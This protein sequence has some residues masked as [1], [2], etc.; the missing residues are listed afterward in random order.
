MEHAQFAG[1]SSITGNEETEIRNIV[2]NVMATFPD[3][4]GGKHRKRLTSQS[5][6]S[7]TLGGEEEEVFGDLFVAAGGVGNAISVLVSDLSDNK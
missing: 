6:F 2:K 5:T 1:S 7:L 3:C 4:L